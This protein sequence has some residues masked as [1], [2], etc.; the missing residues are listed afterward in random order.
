[1]SARPISGS[2]WRRSYDVNDERAQVS[3]IYWEPTANNANMFCFRDTY[4][5]TVLAYSDHM[6]KPGK[7]LPISLN[8]LQVLKALFSFMDGKTGRCD[9]SLDSIAKRSRLSRRTVVRQLDKLRQEKVLDW[10]RRTVRTGNAVGEGPKLHQ[11]SNSYFIDLARVP[12]EIIR[13]LRHKLGKK[14]R[15][16]SRRLLGSGRVPTRTRGQVQKLLNGLVVKRTV[17]KPGLHS[18]LRTLA[19]GT[20][21]DRLKHM[22]GDDTAAMQEHLEMLGHSHHRASANLALYPS[23]RIKR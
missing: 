16:T 11:T 19:N 9:P 5:D 2:A 12:D 8:A 10:V 23:I 14:L 4:R 13:T 15:E 17:P 6:R 20:D 1:M 22:Y 18:A 3:T 21:F 7:T